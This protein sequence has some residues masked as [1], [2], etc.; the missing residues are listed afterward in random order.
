MRVAREIYNNRKYQ[1]RMLKMPY[2]HNI[3]E[4]SPNNL[5]K[6]K[7]AAGRV[8]KSKHLSARNLV[9]VASAEAA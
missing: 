5:A 3:I 9:R 8:R 7:V 1:N 4:M 6:N 2:H